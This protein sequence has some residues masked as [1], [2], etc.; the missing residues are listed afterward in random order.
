M[1]TKLPPFVHRPAVAALMLALIGGSCGPSNDISNPGPEPGTDQVQLTVSTL[2]GGFDTIW[3]LAWGPDN[4]IWV[5]ERP[6]AISRV[7]PSTGAVTRL[8]TVAATNEIGEGGLMGLAFHPDYTT[9]EPWIYVA[10][11]Y[12]AGGS[13][14]NRVVRMRVNGAT[15][16]NPEVI[17]DNMP[18]SSIHNGSRIAVGP[19]RFLYVSMGDAANTGLPQDRNS[20]SGK[21]L[22]LTL[23]GGPAPGNPF[24]NA[25]YS[26]GHR[27]PQGLVFHPG[28]ALYSTEHGPGD[29]DEL[30]RIEMGRNYGWPTVRGKCDGDAGPNENAFCQANNVVEPLA[31]WSPTIAPAGLDYYGGTLI[32]QWR[33]SLLFTTLKDATLYR[34]PLSTDGRS[35]T[36]QEKIFDGQYG[37]LRDVMVAP[38]GSV[39]LGTSNRDGRGSAQG[40][41]DRILRVTA[42]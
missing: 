15:L 39:Y 7:N 20:P 41:D 11:T 29:N 25:V 42:R 37:R 8:G 21:I 40:Q 33:G 22:R 4:A 23:T 32:P 12:S 18:A 9:G 14:R 10:H 34:M 28:G 16:G 17:I 31:N 13:A 27:N 19:D 3:E 2:A 24:G 1:A 6:G 35:V 5:T 36:G 26:Y 38:D 30:N